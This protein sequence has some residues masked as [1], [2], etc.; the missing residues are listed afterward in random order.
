M[1]SATGD[2]HT[3][4]LSPSENSIAN[5]E[6]NGTQFSGI[7]AIVV[8][9]HGDLQIITPLPHT[10]A[11]RAGIIAGD[12]VIA[13]NGTVISHM[14]GSIA[15]ARIHGIAGS[16]VRLTIVRGHRKFSVSVRRAQI[17]AFTAYGRLLGDNLG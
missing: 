8:P 6:L 13:I 14:S 10:P 5:Q 15:V 3:L 7:G 17:P 9:D 2:P 11:A 4:F 1:L 12:K 16:L